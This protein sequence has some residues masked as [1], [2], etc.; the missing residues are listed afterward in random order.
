MELAD[1]NSGF[2][3]ASRNVQLF[4]DNGGNHQL[5]KIRQNSDGTYFI[6]NK[7]SGYY[8]DLEGENTNNGTN[9][10]QHPYNGNN[11]QR[12]VIE[13]YTNTYTISFSEENI[14]MKKGNSKIV[15]INFTGDDIYTLEYQLNNSN[16]CTAQW[17][18]VDYG[19]GTTSVT[20]NAVGAGSTTVA[21]RLKD[22]NDKILF[23]KNINVTVTG[24]PYSISFSADNL[25]MKKDS[26][27]TVN[28][29]FTGE[30]I[31]TLS[32]DLSNSN[33]CTAQWGGVDYGTG[34]TSITINAI[35]AGN[36]FVTINLKDCDDKILFSK[37]ITISVTAPTYTISYNVNQGYGEFT[38]QIKTDGL[39]LT[40]SSVK[41]TRT[42]YEF[43]GWSTNPNATTAE[44]QPGSS[45]SKNENTTLYAVWKATSYTVSYNMNGG[46]GSI[47]SQTKM[48]GQDLILSST[49]PTRTGY[50][51]IGWNINSS[52]TSAQYQPNDKYTT[53]SSV[54]L[55]AVWKSNTYTISYN[56][57]G[58]SGSINP[59]IVVYG[60]SVTISGVIPTRA[61]YQFLGWNTSAN[62]TVAQYQPG[63]KYTSSNSVIL[64]CME[65]IS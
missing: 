21:I 13:P 19:T 61:G 63:S 20:I 4:S 45:F 47:S 14:T 2:L 17:G 44:Y 25:T 16:V 52:A 1:P 59:Q 40:L 58:G 53:N 37:K 36:A 27:K 62:A 54:T 43:L 10:S 34:T 11:N 56:M 12:W 29:R 5:W 9:V 64:C 23:S 65:K 15:N 50:E 26:S 18:D 49:K 7:A 39:S 8:L 55:Y 48:Y 42:G 60:Q 32:Y 30:N 33:I 6:I 41:P 46:N 22:S 31:Y 35:G 38:S 28:I 57:N 51:F 24:D 3:E